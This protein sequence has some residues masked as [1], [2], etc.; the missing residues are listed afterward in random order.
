MLQHASNG[1]FAAAA[2]RVR[3][4]LLPPVLGC[5]VGYYTMLFGGSPNGET[6]SAFADL[7]DPAQP[8]QEASAP[9]KDDAEDPV[10]SNTV[11]QT[12]IGQPAPNN[13]G[14]ATGTESAESSNQS[15]PPTQENSSPQTAPEISASPAQIV[16]SENAGSP[17][18]P[19]I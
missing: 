15:A 14:L 10:A 1:V 3:Y 17:R 11:S 6:G 18:E 9:T 8:T 13:Q 4:P 7:E 5:T 19:L 16:P 2:A 12:P